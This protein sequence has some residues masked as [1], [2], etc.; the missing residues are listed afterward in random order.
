[1]RIFATKVIKASNMWQPARQHNAWL[2]TETISA[3][4]QSMHTHS[5]F[6]E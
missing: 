2:S 3:H 4:S 5:T 1:M 6:G